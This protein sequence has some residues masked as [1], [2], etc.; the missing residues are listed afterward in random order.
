M[1]YIA[2][3]I[4]EEVVAS[5]GGRVVDVVDLSVGRPDRSLRYC[6]RVSGS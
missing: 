4:V 5:A 2:R 6:V 3:S 1:H